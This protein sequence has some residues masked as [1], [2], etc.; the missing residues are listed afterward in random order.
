[1]IPRA[2]TIGLGAVLTLALPGCAKPG[3]EPNTN[4]APAEGSESSGNE[5][6][7]STRTETPE[8]VG[9][10]NTCVDYVSIRAGG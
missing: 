1:M 4:C 10:C 7:G 2:W 6:Q 9:G 5:T 3:C 8:I